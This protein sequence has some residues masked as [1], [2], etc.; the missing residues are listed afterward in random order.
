M[1]PLKTS[2]WGNLETVPSLYAMFLATIQLRELWIPE[3][4][5]TKTPVGPYDLVI[6]PL[7]SQT[8]ANAWLCKIIHHMPFL[9]NR[10]QPAIDARCTTVQ[11]SSFTG[12]GMVSSF[13]MR[14]PYLS[15]TTVVATINHFSGGSV[16]PTVSSLH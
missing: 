11:S 14:H 2:L 16:S 13:R 12:R 1:K 3:G 4:R 15:L 9:W 7:Q 5:Y 8:R 6:L 10:N